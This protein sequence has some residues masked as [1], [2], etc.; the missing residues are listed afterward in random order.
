M[1]TTHRNLGNSNIKI[2]RGEKKRQKALDLAL[3]VFMEFEA[4]VYPKEGIEEFERA[5]KAPDYL[6]QLTF[7]VASEGERTV[8]MLATRNQGSHIALLFV[9]KEYHRKGIARGL[10]NEAIAHCPTDKMT[11]FSSPYAVPIYKAMGFVA[12]NTEQMS[13]G[14]RLTPMER[15]VQP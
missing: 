8:G 9:D 3:K 11:V 15:G 5:L 10:V 4:P 14:I 12:T 7:Y 6:C 2:E 1:E 13:N